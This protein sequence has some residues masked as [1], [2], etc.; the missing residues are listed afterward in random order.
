MSHIYLV[1]NVF[2]R[3]NEDFL[4][5]DCE[6]PVGK[7]KAKQKHDVTTPSTQCVFFH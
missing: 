3:V 1:K 5:A 2:S 6:T 7:S 4:M